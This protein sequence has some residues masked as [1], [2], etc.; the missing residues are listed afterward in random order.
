MHLFSEQGF[1]GTSVAAIERAAGLTPGAGGLYHHFRTKEDVL[2]QALERHLSRLGALHDIRALFAGVHDLEVE[3]TL[4]ARYVMAELDTESELVQVLVLE[5][6]RR[7]ELV[8]EIL[9]RLVD[10]SV[11]EFTGWLTDDW[12][13]P[14]EQARAVA[15]LALVSL[16][17]HRLVTET[18]LPTEAF[19]TTWVRTFGQA[20]A[21]S[22][23]PTGRRP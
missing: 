2:T 7:P 19:V 12:S 10:S 21:G 4:I 3:L 14:A 18:V 16:F 11:E 1:R 13:V 23:R 20:L 22:Q 15:A 9:Q 6:R 8:G 5:G 17:A